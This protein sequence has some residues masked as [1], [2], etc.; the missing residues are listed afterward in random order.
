MKR[1][2]IKIQIKKPVDKVFAF[3]TTPPNSTLWIDSFVEEKTSDW[4]IKV[5]T[6]YILTDKLGNILEYLTIAIQKDKLFELKMV[7]SSYHVRYQYKKITENITEFDYF[8][9]V[10]RGDIDGPFTMEHLKKLKKVIE[11]QN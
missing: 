6:K 3:T 1:N 2:R 11:S 7:G 5:G 9:W 8:E 4:P 10:D